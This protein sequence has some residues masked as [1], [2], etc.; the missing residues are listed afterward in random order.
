MFVTSALIIPKYIYPSQPIS[1]IIR[2]SKRV[3]PQTLVSFPVSLPT[4]YTFSTQTPAVAMSL[5]SNCKVCTRDESIWSSFFPNNFK[6]SIKRRWLTLNPSQDYNLLLIFSIPVFSNGSKHTKNNMGK[7][8]L[9]MWVTSKLSP[10]DD[11]STFHVCIL[12]IRIF[13]SHSQLS[14]T[15]PNTR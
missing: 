13:F 5:L 7:M 12:S 8:P 6:S 15:S 9:L 11:N 3:I 10:D 14:Q 1:P 2:P 4:H